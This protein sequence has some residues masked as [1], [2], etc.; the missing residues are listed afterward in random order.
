MGMEMGGMRRRIR[1]SF[2]VGVEMKLENYEIRTGWTMNDG[3]ALVE[4]FRLAL[5]STGVSMVEV[6]H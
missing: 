3:H 2:E 4:D 1:W 6:V 5:H